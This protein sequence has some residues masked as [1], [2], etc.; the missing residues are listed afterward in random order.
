MQ[1]GL[2]I[3]QRFKFKVVSLNKKILIDDQ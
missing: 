1:G 3:S 2:S